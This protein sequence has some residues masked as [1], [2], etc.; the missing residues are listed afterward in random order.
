MTPE[1]FS[2]LNAHKYTKFGRHRNLAPGI[3]ASL[4]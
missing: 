3:S 2:A 4:Q 1:A